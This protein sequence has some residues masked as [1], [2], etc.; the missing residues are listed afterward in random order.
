MNEGR[1]APSDI[2]VELLLKAMQESENNKFLVDGFP[3]NEEN[4]A[5]FESKVSLQQTHYSSGFPSPEFSVLYIMLLVVCMANIA[6]F[7]TSA[8]V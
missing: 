3:R 2:T 8:K 4:R 6:I 7:P 5:A 1:I